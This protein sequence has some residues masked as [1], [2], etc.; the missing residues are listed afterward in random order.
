MNDR[1][2]AVEALAMLASVAGRRGEAYRAG[3]LWG[4]I[5]AE[6]SRGPIGAIS[7]PVSPW[8]GWEPERERYLVHVEAVK[9]PEFERG[10]REGLGATLDEAQSAVIR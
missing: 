5:E 10:R 3:W 2:H 8:R 9:G 4:A 6:E 1:A 7:P